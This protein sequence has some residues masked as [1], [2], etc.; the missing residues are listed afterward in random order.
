M[1][2]GRSEGGLFVAGGEQREK[3]ENGLY[4]SPTKHQEIESDAGRRLQVERLME[5]SARKL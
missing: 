4:E 1:L 3:K 5:W 2:G